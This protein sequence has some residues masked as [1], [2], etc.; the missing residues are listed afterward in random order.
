MSKI[1]AWIGDTLNK[2]LIIHGKSYGVVTKVMPPDRVR[3]STKLKSK[4]RGG[5]RLIRDIRL[6]HE[7]D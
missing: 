5:V 3:T 2:E 7:D 6:Y 4:I 1:S